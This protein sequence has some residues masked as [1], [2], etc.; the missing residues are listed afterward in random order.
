MTVPFFLVFMG[1]IVT[2]S[3][4]KFC[5]S[6]CLSLFC[7]FRHLQISYDYEIWQLYQ[8]PNQIKLG[9]VVSLIRPSGGGS[10]GTV[11]LGKLEKMTYF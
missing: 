6:V 4:R 2:Y 8:G 5:Q 3:D 7:K 11:N 1:L 10:G 9:I